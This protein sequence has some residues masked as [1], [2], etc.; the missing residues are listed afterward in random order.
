M[1]IAVSEEQAQFLADLV[2]KGRYVSLEEAHSA[3]LRLLAEA[4]LAEGRFAPIGAD[5]AA[6][7]KM[8]ACQA[9]AR[10]RRA[11]DRIKLQARDAD[12]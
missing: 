10:G 8:D 5:I 9:V 6:R 1:Q 2:R 7:M 3:A 12:A 4:M 11:S